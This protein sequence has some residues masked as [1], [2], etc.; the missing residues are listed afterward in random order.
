MPRA[1]LCVAGLPEGLLLAKREMVSRCHGAERPIGGTIATH[2]RIADLRRQAGR[3]VHAIGI[4]RK[5]VAGKSTST[6]SIRLYVTRK[7]PRS[8]IGAA[9]L[10]PA[11]VDG[12]PTDIIE[13]PPAFFAAP[14]VFPCTLKRLKRQRP[15]HA[16]TS[17]GHVTVVGG[18]LGA[19]VR[20]RLAGEEALHLALSNNHVLAD[21]GAVGLGTGV[22]QPSAG[23]GG[24]EADT[25]GRLL[26]FAPI[27]ADG[28]TENRVDAAVAAMDDAIRISPGICGVGTVHGTAAASLGMAV[29]KHARTTGYSQGV[30][31]D[32]DC[33]VMLPIDRNAPNRVA[34]FVHQLRI[35]SKNGTSRFA[36]SG[37]SGALIVAK[38]SGAATGLLFACPDH[39]GYAYA[40]PIQ[41]V[42][43][44]LRVDLA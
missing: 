29:H 32:I 27:V 36:Q 8:L 3:L 37:D 15:L 24:M 17:F 18:T 20:S 9:E 28:T 31:D 14:P 40:N 25:V 2:Y 22:C 13:A 6:L 34:R 23:D 42:L 11:L 30:I 39:G 41:A 21:F 16:G 10:I 19:S 44:E 43:D 1:P 35:R 12:I 7:L 38:A 4:G 5:L 33:D 26:R